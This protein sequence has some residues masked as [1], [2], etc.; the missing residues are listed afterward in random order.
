[1]S[2]KALAYNSCIMSDDTQ[3]LIIEA[4]ILVVGAGGLGGFVSQG[5]VRL[6][7]QNVTVVDG[8][9]FSD[10]NLNRQFFC[11]TSSINQSKA[12]FCVQNMLDVYPQG[13]FKAINAYITEKNISSIISNYDF[14]FDCSDNIKTKLMLEAHC[15][16]NGIV[17]L[18]AGINGHYGQVTIIHGKPLLSSLFTR[19]T[20]CRNAVILPQI[21]AGLQLNLFV[22]YLSKTHTPNRLYL[23][24]LHSMQI[25]YINY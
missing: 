14:V 23:I 12:V 7:A 22:Q 17:L 4:K 10:T 13:D 1:M 21:A 20:K 16:Q 11:T 8:D 24:D 6:G 3:E 19:E 5:L 18:H 9:I 25:S 15:I 2:S